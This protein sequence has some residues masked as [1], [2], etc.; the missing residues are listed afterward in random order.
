[1]A[2]GDATTGQRGWGLPWSSLSGRLCAGADF[3]SFQ[4]VGEVV[5]PDPQPNQRIT[6][7]KDT[8][9]ERAV[10]SPRWQSGDM[11]SH[12]PA[13]DWVTSGR[14]APTGSRTPQVYRGVRLDDA[15]RSSQRQAGS[16]PLSHRAS[17]AGRR[18]ERFLGS[19]RPGGVQKEEMGG[20]AEPPGTSLAPWWSAV[21]HPEWWQDPKLGV[22]S[23]FSIYKMS[24]SELPN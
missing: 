11:T 13:A 12:G 1:M 8:K 19:S 10:K 2:T 22:R 17:A 4:Q 15:S 9:Q 16:G 5:A 6:K 7:T 20:G 21:S 23:S 24:G 14:T 3:Y 18:R